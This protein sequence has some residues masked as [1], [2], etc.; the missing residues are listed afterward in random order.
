M[1]F[2]SLLTDT[3]IIYPFAAGS[4]DRYG[5]EADGFGTGVTTTGRLFFTA[6]DELEVD[7]DT[8][9]SRATLILRASET[10]AATSEVGFGSARYRVNGEPRIAKGASSAHHIVC[11]LLKVDAG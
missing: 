2:E 8:R 4:A 7:R 11:D 10:I 6:T 1:S 5:D 9:I 3:V